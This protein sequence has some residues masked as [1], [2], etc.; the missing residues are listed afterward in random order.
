MTDSPTA[1]LRLEDLGSFDALGLV[2]EQ[3]HRIDVVTSR[4][5]LP[6]LLV[7]KEHAGAVVV[8]NNG[9]VD[10]DLADRRVVFQRS[11]WSTQIHHHQ[12]Y[13]YDPATGAPDHLSL[14]WGQLDRE[15]WVVPDAVRAVRSLAT[16]LGCP[17]PQ[18]RIHYGSSAGAFMAL[19]MM[20]LDP[21]SSA[22]LNNAQFDWTR[23]MPTG[24]NP[25]RQRRFG[26]M[27]PTE[28]RAELP[29]RTSALRLVAAQ[30][31][32]LNVEYHVNLA[33]KHDRVIDY[34]MFHE[35]LLD[36]PELVADVDV[37][38]Y[39]DEAAG[40]NPLSRERT[41]DI[42]NHAGPGVPAEPAQTSMEGRPN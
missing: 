13:L 29:L 20:A 12:L 28:L 31:A 23:W 11:S 6:F 2:P 35:F 4:T 5:V 27:L 37:R 1:T 18:Q 3:H 16:A 22:R 25:L 9:A 42:I 38:C 33:S 26:N 15:H 34:P 36:H 41:V 7:R 21:G 8:M 24:V 19:A 30:G 39:Y 14:A 10:Q 17:L 40:H 32:P